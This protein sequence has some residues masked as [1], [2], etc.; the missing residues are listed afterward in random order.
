LAGTVVGAGDGAASGPAVG[1][2]L[3]A[4]SSGVTGSGDSVSARRIGDR[5]L[6]RQDAAGLR[7][8]DPV[9]RP[10]VDRERRGLAR[11]RSDRLD[12]GATVRGP[13]AGGGGRGDDAVDGCRGD[14]RRAVQRRVARRGGELRGRVDDVAR[15]GWRVGEALDLDGAAGRSERRRAD[16]RRHLAGRD[17]AGGRRGA[18]ARRRRAARAALL[19][20]APAP[21]APP[22]PSSFVSAISGPRPPA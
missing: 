15:R 12:G 10:R 22:M 8:V 13:V 2:A 7:R 5:L 21:P 4:V 17:R 11:R 3:G 9:D 16:D 14:G 1:S 6:G 18:R 19:P 20:A